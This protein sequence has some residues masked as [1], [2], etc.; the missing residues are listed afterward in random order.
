[1]QP[2]RGTHGVARSHCTPP[3]LKHK[4]KRATRCRSSIFHFDAPESVCSTPTVA[5]VM[6]IMQE[7]D[8]SHIPTPPSPPYCAHVD[9]GDAMAKDGRDTL[10]VLRAELNFV[11]KGGYGRSPREPSR[12]VLALE[13]S[14]TCMNYDTKNNKTPCSECLLMQFVPES[15]QREKVPCRHIPLTDAGDTLLQLYQGGTDQEIEESL[16]HWLEK[17]IEKLEVEK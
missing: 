5:D 15:S 10:E 14:P 13:D 17:E 3:A 8:P 1:L 4:M 6:S 7:R 16:T 12:A 9:G 11:K 2:V